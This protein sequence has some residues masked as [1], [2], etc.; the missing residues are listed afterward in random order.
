MPRALLALE[1]T[2]V[3]VVH[4]KLSELNGFDFLKWELEIIMYTNITFILEI[5]L[6]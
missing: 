2:L 3:L 1:P 4:V 5:S 6:S